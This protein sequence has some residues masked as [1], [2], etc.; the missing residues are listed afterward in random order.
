MT[1]FAGRKTSDA[2]GSLASPIASVVYL[3]SSSSY[4]NTGIY[5]ELG[6]LYYRILYYITGTVESRVRRQGCVTRA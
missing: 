2:L 1:D 6:M 3:L 4:I 5:G